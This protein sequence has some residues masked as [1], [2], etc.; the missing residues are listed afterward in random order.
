MLGILHRRLQISLPRN[1]VFVSKSNPE[2]GVL[3]ATFSSS[4]IAGQDK[5]EKGNFLTVSF[6]INSCGLSPESAIVTSKKVNFRNPETPDSVL[7]FFRDHKFSETQISA[8]IRKRP[9]FLLTDPSKTLLP[10][11]EFFYSKGFSKEDFA[12]I[13]SSDP[14]ILCRS[15][16]GYIIP[17]YNL[18]KSVLASDKQVVSALKHQWVPL[19]GHSEYMLSNIRLLRDLGVSDSGIASVLQSFP[20]VVMPKTEAF[21]EIVKKVEHLGF[22]PEKFSFLLAIRIFSTKSHTNAWKRCWEVYKRYGWSEDENLHAFR[23]HPQCMLLSEEKIVKTMNF[24]VNEMEWPSE[25]IVKCPWILFYSFEKRTFPRCSVVR[26]LLSKGLIK[27]RELTFV[28]ILKCVE[29]DFLARY[30]TKYPEEA[31]LLLSVY[32][33]KADPEKLVLVD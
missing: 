12:K 27:K 18:L 32:Q 11:L 5:I 25:K 20:E 9:S 19:E 13:L 29:K 7:A 8:F 22:T 6:L 17:T 15:L 26:V 21:S 23:V 16:N 2:L 33:G 31:P 24:L 10:K 3:T 1:G 28:S 14:S 4:A 30:V